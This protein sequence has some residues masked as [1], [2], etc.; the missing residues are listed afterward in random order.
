MSPWKKCGIGSTTH[1][2]LM[3]LC[4]G[5]DDGVAVQETLRILT[6]DGDEQVGQ[7]GDDLP[8]ALAV[9]VLD[10]GDRGVGGV[11]VRWEAHEPGGALSAATSPSITDDFGVVRVFR[12]LGPDAGSILTT[13]AIE[14]RSGPPAEFTAVAQVQGAVRL[15]LSPDD[16]GDGQA[17]TVLATVAPLRV[18]ALDHR[19]APASGVMVGWRVV[20][21]GALSA[22]DSETDSGGVAEVSLTLGASTRWP[23]VV[24]AR[25]PGLIG[26]PIL[27]EIQVLPGQPALIQSVGAGEQVGL[28]GTEL[29][30]AYIVR[31]VDAHGNPIGDETLMVEVEWEVATGGGEVRPESS[32]AGGP[33][34]G[35][36][37]AWLTLGPDEGPNTLVA[38]AIGLPGQ[39][40]VPF[41][42]TGVTALVGVA[43]D[44]PTGDCWP[45]YYPFYCPPIFIPAEVTVP[46]GGIV[47]W[48][49][50]PG[51]RDPHN[52]TFEDAPTQPESSRTSS[53]GAHTRT[54]EAPGI[55]RYRCTVH[56]TSFTEGMVGRVIVD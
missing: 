24:E 14:G 21:H 41:T 20:G 51:P 29:D 46:V 4:F 42:A 38:R 11:V 56:S 52:V 5:C 37:R 8:R 18:L 50:R 47:G 23:A 34:D 53:R 43:L 32:F 25:V 7:A 40:E 33:P 22:S 26:S 55:Y 28:P 13:A 27:F 9:R 3:M 19:D 48:G 2:V 16:H 54:F 31:I 49:W 10:S 35:L 17:D 6:Y 1:L 30:E 45:Y 39:P 12:R 15:V 44:D 36:A